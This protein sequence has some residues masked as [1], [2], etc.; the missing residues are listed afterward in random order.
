[1]PQCSDRNDLKAIESAIDRR[2]ANVTARN[3][4]SPG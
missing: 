1:M 4:K 3:A 2:D